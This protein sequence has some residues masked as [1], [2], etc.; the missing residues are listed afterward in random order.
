[1]DTLR[2]IKDLVEKISTDTHKVY[3]KGNHSASIRA[4]KNAQLLKELI[5]D[6]RKEV[7]TEIKRQ[8]AIKPKTHKKSRYNSYKNLKRKEEK[9]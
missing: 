4:R 7:L 2:Q 3:E 9:V 8:N 1:M 5:V 6:F